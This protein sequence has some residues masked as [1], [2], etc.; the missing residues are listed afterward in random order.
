MALEV[1]QKLKFLV[2]NAVHAKKLKELHGRVQHL[3]QILKDIRG[4]TTESSESILKQ[5]G[6]DCLA[7]I[8]GILQQMKALTKPQLALKEK[9]MELLAKI[10]LIQ[11][12]EE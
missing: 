8:D 7:N 9:D 10:A 11:K 2:L 4:D 12:K 1:K 6:A 5:A 3:E